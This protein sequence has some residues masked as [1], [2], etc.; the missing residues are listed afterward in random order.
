MGC[1]IEMISEIIFEVIG[2]CMI[3]LFRKLKR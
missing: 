1:I 3:G 2:E